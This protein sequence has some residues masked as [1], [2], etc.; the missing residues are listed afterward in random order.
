MAAR[1]AFATGRR[2]GPG[3]AAQVPVVTAVSPDERRASIE[4]GQRAHRENVVA[5][6]SESAAERTEVRRCLLE[7]LRCECPCAGADDGHR[8]AARSRP[9]RQTPELE[10]FRSLS[11]AL[12]ATT[13]DD[14]GDR[15]GG[16]LQLHWATSSISIGEKL[17][18]I[19]VGEPVPQVPAHR[20]QDHLRREA[21]PCQ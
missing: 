20:G 13:G 6:G 17:L 18:E 11:D 2:A 9:G 5:E 4:F 1:T 16:V 3:H 7:A 19:A 8:S 10:D 21:E 12:A 14:P 15:C